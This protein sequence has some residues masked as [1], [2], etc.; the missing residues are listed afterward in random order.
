MGWLFLLKTTFENCVIK[1][2]WDSNGM[3]LSPI[4][5]IAFIIQKTNKNYLYDFQNLTWKEGRSVRIETYIV[6][7]WDFLKVHNKMVYHKEMSFA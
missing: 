5:I 1:W 3:L 7:T 6:W 4:P 2:T